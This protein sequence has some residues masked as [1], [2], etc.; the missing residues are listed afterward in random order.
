MAMRVNIAPLEFLV[1]MAACT[2]IGLLIGLNNATPSKTVEAEYQ[3]ITFQRLWHEWPCSYDS[4]LRH[5][6][7]TM[8]V[9]CWDGRV[10]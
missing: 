3:P 5:N 1:Y 4:V 10:R 6:D 9:E 2:A 8:V 7:T